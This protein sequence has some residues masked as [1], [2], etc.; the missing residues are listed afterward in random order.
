[1][2]P[3]LTP[4]RSV[5]AEELRRLDMCE[6]ALAGAFRR[7]GLQALAEA[8]ERLAGELRA[9]L[10]ALGG[11][12][13]PA[14]DESWLVGTLADASQ[15]ALATYHD[16]LGDHDSGT[17]SLFRERAIPHHRAVLAHLRAGVF[18]DSEL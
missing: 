15:L 7:A 6:R 4:F 11:T 17:V 9:R 10:E 5:R 3:S 2:Q 16:H 13:D 1:M 14:V 18:R 12:A 8:G